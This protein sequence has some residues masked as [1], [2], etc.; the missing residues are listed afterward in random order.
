MQVSALSGLA[1]GGVAALADR[2]AAVDRLHEVLAAF[3]A[4]LVV[5]AYE[6]TVGPV[7]L[8]AGALGSRSSSRRSFGADTLGRARPGIDGHLSGSCASLRLGLRVVRRCDCCLANFN[9][10]PDHE[11]TAFGAACVVGLM[12]NLGARYFHIPQAVALVPG[13]LVLVPGSLS[14]ESIL[15][16]FQNDVTSAANMASMPRSLRIHI[17]AATLLS[18][19]SVRPT[20]RATLT[21]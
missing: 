5:E 11:V 10:V 8:Y 2:N 6:L 15:S 4:T 13:V 16:V 12:T 17:V 9:A 20:M 19:L 21:K 3:I 14:Q 1:I 7:A 18:Q